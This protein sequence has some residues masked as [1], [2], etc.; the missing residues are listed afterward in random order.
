MRLAFVPGRGWEWSPSL[1]GTLPFPPAVR[2]GQPPPGQGTLLAAAPVA[3]DG[4]S[5]QHYLA[6]LK[7]YFFLPPASVYSRDRKNELF[8]FHSP[9]SGAYLEVPS[10]FQHQGKSP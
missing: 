5:H 7:N 3:L 6:F 4:F 9:H 2:L 8:S 1:P 10:T